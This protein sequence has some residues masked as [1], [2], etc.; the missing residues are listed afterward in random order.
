[1][2]ATRGG[3]KNSISPANLVPNSA[4]DVVRLVGSRGEGK[5]V[6]EGKGHPTVPHSH[7]LLLSLSSKFFWNIREILTLPPGQMEQVRSA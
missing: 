4:W 2:Q 7:T 6:G 5:T 3:R 1:M